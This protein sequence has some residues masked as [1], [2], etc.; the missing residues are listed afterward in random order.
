MEG[1]ETLTDIVFF[2]GP[3]VVG[4]EFQSIQW[5]RPTLVVPIQGSGSSYFANL[6]E[7]L[8][9]SRGRILPSLVSRYAP[10]VT[11][12]GKIA[13]CAYSAGHGLLDRVFQVPEERQRIAASVVSDATFAGLNAPPKEGYVQFGVDAAAGRSLFLATTANTS[14]G[15]HA[16]GRDS[17]LSVWREVERRTGR[18]E[19][20]ASAVGDM[21][22]PSGGVWSIGSR[23]TWYDYAD[24]TG[25]SDISHGDH[26]A[27]AA[28]AWRSYLV[29]YLGGTPDWAIG[30]GLAAIGGAGALYL[31]KRRLKM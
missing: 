25:R 14:D 16:T 28:D 4:P 1:A 22:T 19:R 12:V 24:E 15:S 3:V 21:P 2:A 5:R 30:A 11:D 9:D 29:P 17:W 6:A 26:H 23:L 20:A 31:Y 18:G 7:R 27:L 10:D 13:L 8:R